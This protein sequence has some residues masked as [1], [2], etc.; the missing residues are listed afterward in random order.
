MLHVLTLTWDGEQKMRNLLP[1]L[2]A[3]LSIFH[4]STNADA[5]YH[6]RDNGSK[7]GTVDYLKNS[8]DK[9]QMTVYEIGHNRDSFSAGMNFLAKEAG[10]KSNDYILLL[11]NDV[12]FNDDHDLLKMYDLIN[13]T[14]AGVVGCRLL[15]KGTNQLQHAGVIFSSRY[16][17]MPYH[18]RP[19]DQADKDSEYNRYFQAVTAACCLVRGSSWLNA[20]GMDE[21]FKWAFDDIDLCLSIGKTEKIAYCGGTRICHE[22]SATLKKN[23]VHLMSMQQNVKR[24]KDKWAGK[25]KLDLEKYETDKEYQKIKL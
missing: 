1:G 23:P 4:Q 7:D 21:G 24:F 2:Q 20:S 9:S 17:E 18:Y 10:I 6:V 16:N 5:H 13:K 15:Y 14:K 8:L 25:Y 3:N 12:V 22:E 19:G 11:N